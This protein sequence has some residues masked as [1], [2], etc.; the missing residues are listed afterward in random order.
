MGATYFRLDDDIQQ[1]L[2]GFS[3]DI[4]CRK[5]ANKK[6]SWATTHEARASTM[7]AFVCMFK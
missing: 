3:N 1:I 5:V 4:K 7:Y 2:S 6:I